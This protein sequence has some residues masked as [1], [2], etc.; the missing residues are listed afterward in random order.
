M[1]L[2]KQLEEMQKQLQVKDEQI[3]GLQKLLDQQ[4]QLSLQDKQE[5]KLMRER[6]ALM[7][8]EQEIDKTG[9]EQVEKKKSFFQRLFR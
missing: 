9:S 3:A 5:L 7:E 2:I 8:P 1:A 6:L 4:Q